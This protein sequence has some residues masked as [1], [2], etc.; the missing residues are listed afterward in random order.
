MVPDGYLSE[1]EGQIDEE[2]DDEDGEGGAEKTSGAAKPITLIT[3]D[4]PVIPLQVGIYFNLNG[5]FYIS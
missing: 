1:D 5:T 3:A 2:E 4:Q